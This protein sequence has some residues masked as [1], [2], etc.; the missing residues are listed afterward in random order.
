MLAGQL[1]AGA[2]VSFTVTDV[3]QEVEFPEASV[4]VNVTLNVPATKAPADGFCV[5]VDTEQLSETVTSGSMFCMVV[6]QTPGPEVRVCA[7]GQVI[8][9]A[10]LSDT[11]TVKEQVAVLPL[12]SVAV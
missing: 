12:A 10:L 7:P 4:A 2:C 1:I 9:G 8:T 5:M 11:V 3:V 6:P